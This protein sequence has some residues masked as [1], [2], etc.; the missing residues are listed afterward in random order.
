M[1]LS[2]YVPANQIDLSFN[3][4]WFVAQIKLVY[5]TNQIDL[6]VVYTEA[7]G[8]TWV[9]KYSFPRRKKTGAELHSPA[10]LLYNLLILNK[11]FSA[12]KWHHYEKN[13]TI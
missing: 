13:K 1:F 8:N 2:L 5:S 3:L 9:K 4:N 11:T 6:R 12:T 7:P 10:P